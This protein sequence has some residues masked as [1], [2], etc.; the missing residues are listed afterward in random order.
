[1]V[2]EYMV[3]SLE[4]IEEFLAMCQPSSIAEMLE[5]KRLLREQEEANVSHCET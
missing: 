3:P 2:I 5:Q 1:M 4:E